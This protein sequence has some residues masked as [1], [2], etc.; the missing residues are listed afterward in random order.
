MLSFLC[1]VFCFFFFFQAEDGIRDRTVTGVQTCALPISVLQLRQ[2]LLLILGLQRLVLERRVTGR[3]RQPVK[4]RH[5]LHALARALNDTPLAAERL[6]DHA[7]LAEH[8]RLLLLPLAERERR[9]RGRHVGDGQREGED[10]GAA[11]GSHGAGPTTTRL[12]V[13]GG[14][15]WPATRS[16]SSAVTRAM[17]SR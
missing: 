4:R 11:G 13:W 16:T 1:C 6:V 8:E 15:Y 5:D 2:Q 17:S 14:K 3:Q 10:D 7:A 9:A 12:N